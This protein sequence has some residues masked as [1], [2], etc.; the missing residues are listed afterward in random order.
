[1]FCEN[2]SSFEIDHDY[3]VR[4]RVYKYD[5]PPNYQAFTRSNSRLFYKPVT[6]TQGNQ[7]FTGNVIKISFKP[8]KN[9][10]ICMFSSNM[11]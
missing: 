9:K 2:I 7:N 10:H 6:V 1:M 8:R 5:L 4:T 11:G 3:S